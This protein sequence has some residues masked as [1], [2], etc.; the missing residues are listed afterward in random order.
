[1]KKIP[2]G[3]LEV[4]VRRVLRR[5][6]NQNNKFGINEELSN[7][8]PEEVFDPRTADHQEGQPCQGRLEHSVGSD[9]GHEECDPEDGVSQDW[10]Q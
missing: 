9:P 4:I 8:N 1:M 7:D 3:S 6:G 5:T 10:H 2:P